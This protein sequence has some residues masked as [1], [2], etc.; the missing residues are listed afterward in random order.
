MQFGANTF[1]FHLLLKILSFIL[2]RDQKIVSIVVVIQLGKMKKK[3]MFR[4]FYQNFGMVGLE[5]E[6]R[7]LEIF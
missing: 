7:E 2:V 6:Q 3:K 4:D 5:V 1:I